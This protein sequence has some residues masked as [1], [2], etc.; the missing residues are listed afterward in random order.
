MI[1]VLILTDRD[2]LDPITDNQSLKDARLIT[3]KRFSVVHLDYSIVIIN[4]K[5]FKNRSGDITSDPIAI[6]ANEITQNSTI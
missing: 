6:L 4:G 5:V 1:S 3:G 2:F